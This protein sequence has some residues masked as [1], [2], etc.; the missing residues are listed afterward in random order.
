[1]MTLTLRN[2]SGS[3]FHFLP[4]NWLCTIQFYRPIRTIHSF[5]HEETAQKVSCNLTNSNSI[6][7]DT[8]LIF[9]SQSKKDTG[10]S[11]YSYST[12]PQAIKDG[13]THQE[14]GDIKRKLRENEFNIED[15]SFSNDL[16]AQEI[17]AARETLSDYKGVFTKNNQYIHT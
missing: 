8:R 14:I 4:N 5:E 16:T 10:Q 9:D 3:D 7:S 17:Q 12:Y 13:L 11:S 15:F 6:I 2:V 1:R